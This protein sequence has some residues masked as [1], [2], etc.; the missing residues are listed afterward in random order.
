MT[1]YHHIFLIFFLMTLEIYPLLNPGWLDHCFPLPSQY[2]LPQWFPLALGCCFLTF[3][4]C[5]YF[6][7]RFISHSSRKPSQ[8]SPA[9]KEILFIFLPPLPISLCSRRLHTPWCTL[10]ILCS[11]RQ[12]KETFFNWCI[13]DIQYY[14]QLYNL[15]IQHLCVLQNDHHDKSSYHLAPYMVITVLLTMFPM[16]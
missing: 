8:N 12:Y 9:W 1:L 5:Q 10:V 6:K 14:F 4:T 13:V 7:A 16:L 15:M 11:M 2:S 3:K